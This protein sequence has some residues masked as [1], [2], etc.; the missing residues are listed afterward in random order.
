MLDFKRLQTPSRDG[1]ILIEPEP[2]CW[3]GLVDNISQSRPD[4]LALAGVNIAE[5]RTDVRR[6][7][8]NA[9]ADAIVIA[10]GHQPAYIHPGVWAKNVAVARAAERF[11]TIAGD[12]IVDND[13]PETTDLILPAAEHDGLVKTNTIRWGDEPAHAAYEGRSPLS[14]AVIESNRGLMARLMGSGF[15]ESAIVAYLDGL[16]EAH[17]ARDLVEQHLA[18]RSR[19]D[20]PLGVS[21]NWTRVS[22]AFGGP[23]V[24]DLLLHADRFASAYNE[25]LREYRLAH[26]VRGH[27]RPLPDLG[28]DGD[29]VETALWI[30]QPRNRRQRLWVSREH[31]VLCLY[32]DRA[33]VGRVGESELVRAPDTTLASLSPWVVRPRALTLTLWVRLLVCDLFVH[34]IGGAKYDR[35]TDRIF[36]SYYRCEPPPLACVSAT[37]HLPLPRHPR[38]KTYVHEARHR[39]RD[40]R[41]NPQRYLPDAPADLLARRLALIAESDTLRATRGPRAER[42]RVFTELRRTNEK[43]AQARP[44][45]EEQLRVDLADQTRKAASDALALGREYFYAL[46]PRQRLIGLAER[47]AEGLTT[48]RRVERSF[49]RPPG[50]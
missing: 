23:F 41:Y 50:G 35:I 19:V 7:I 5:L 1:D 15:G 34:G 40:L 24:A 11:G 32:A 42:R 49:E 37:L 25:A 48:G 6:R 20:V 27:D 12:L 33:P 26:D 3:A 44:D 43:L 16:A 39:L 36:Q 18:G 22:T 9:P 38:A 17:K 4:G 30:Y 31:G 14:A 13:A 47:I 10:C 45:I 2:D 29:R 28:R 46:Q 21:L 8:W